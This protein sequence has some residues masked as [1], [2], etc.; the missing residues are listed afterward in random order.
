MTN[1]SNKSCIENQNTHVMPNNF[2]PK[3]VPFI[4]QCRKMWWNQ[5]HCNWQY[6]GALHA[7]LVRLHAHKHTLVP[8]HPH[9]HICMYAHTHTN[10]KICNTDVFIWQQWFRERASMLHYTYTG[11]LVY[12]SVKSSGHISS[13]HKS[14]HAQCFTC[15]TVHICNPTSRALCF[16]SVLIASLLAWN[17][18]TNWQ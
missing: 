14:A 4:R 15:V 5:R 7:G 18:T 8:M 2:F 16:F 1:V 12:M 10:T 17:V 11:C 6:G 13:W 9:T 3:T